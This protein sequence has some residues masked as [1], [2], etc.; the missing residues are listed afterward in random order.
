MF[1]QCHASAVEPLDSSVTVFYFCYWT[2]SLVLFVIG[3][4]WRLRFQLIWVLQFTKF[5]IIGVCVSKFE[6]F[7]VLG[8]SVWFSNGLFCLCSWLIWHWRLLIWTTTFF[9]LNSFLGTCVSIL[10]FYPGRHS[11][12]LWISLFIFFCVVFAV[13]FLISYDNI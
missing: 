8:L 1:F 13:N 11:S 5:G 2:V 10:W 7:I 6:L 3:L 9:N 4:Q 12:S